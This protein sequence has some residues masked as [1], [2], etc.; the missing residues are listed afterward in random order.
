MIKRNMSCRAVLAAHSKTMFSA[1]VK[2]CSSLLLFPFLF[3]FFNGWSHAPFYRRQDLRVAPRYWRPSPSIGRS[4]PRIG[5]RRRMEPSPT[6]VCERFGRPYSES[7]DSFKRF[8][9][10][11]LTLVA[12]WEEACK[13]VTRQ[14][15]SK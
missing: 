4:W 7:V 3:V 1:E 15:K 13:H 5:Q 11:H 12:V 10:F 9:L 6:D 14:S 8:P 2:V